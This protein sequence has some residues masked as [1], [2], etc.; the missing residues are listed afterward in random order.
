[1]K[2]ASTVKS[3]AQAGWDLFEEL[4]NQTAK[5]M[6]A[7]ILHQ[8]GLPEMNPFG[9]RPQTLA[10]EDLLQAREEKRLEEMKK[11]EEQ[12]AKE[13]IAIVRNEY[14]T[15]EQKSQQEQQSLKQEVS[16]LTAEVAKLAKTAGIDTK[17]HL[18]QMPKKVGILHIKR[19]TAIVKTLRLKA[20]EAK[21]GKELVSQR[22]NAK[23]ST[24]MLA[25]V[26]GKQM[27]IHEQGT[28]QLQG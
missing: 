20:D 9:N 11:E 2:A 21:S 28:L 17:V 22:S 24:G 10:K 13:H 25:W 6:A 26:S 14:R 1:M 5:P 4:G 16:E 19:L 3:A 8:F 15:F 18:E 23:K 12:K 7:D 27:K